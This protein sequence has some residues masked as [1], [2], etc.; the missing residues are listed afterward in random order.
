M[1]PSRPWLTPVSRVLAVAVV[2]GA[3][4]VGA[5][6]IGAA[7]EAT[8]APDGASSAAT[9]LTTSYCPG[10]P[11]AGG[12]EDSPAVDVTGAIDAMAA[13]GE[14]LDGV[15]SPSDDP[16]RITVEELSKASATDPKD[17]SESGP[18]Q[19]S[20]DELGA[21]SVRVRG[22]GERAPGL[23][24]TESFTASGEDVQGLAALP[25]AAPTADA[26]LV[27]GG[28]DRGRQERLVLT[29]PGGNAVSARVEAVGADGGG[30]AKDRSVVVPAGGRS[31]VLL[32]SLGGTEAPQ[33]VHVTTTGG[34][35][36]PVIVDQHLDGLTPAGV[37][38]VGPTAQPGTR[39]VLPGN[40][41]GSD[42]GLVIAAPGDRDA[43]VQ[44]RRLSEDA[45]RSAEVV[46][47]PA[48]EV[49]DVDLETSD[50][51]RSWVV[52]SD[53]PVVAASWTRVEGTQG[54]SD[55]AWSV[56]TPAIGRLAGVALPSAS[57]D[58]ARTF[59]E[60]TAADAPAEVEVLVSRD[61][62]VSTEE[63][64][65]DKARSKALPVGRADAVWVRP[66]SGRVHSAALVLS[67]P[68]AQEAQA[69]SLP[70]LPSRVAVRDVPVV[71]AR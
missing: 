48:G 67:A 39:L 54:R 29:N 56:A 52:E 2:A 64:S 34:L 68:G 11:F 42:R 21:E 30:D 4:V 51:M 45:A 61:G 10:D 36:A 62:E 18:T 32:D 7:P 35:V 28:G 27:A 65:L 25:C 14:V 40:A 66:V 49:F 47:V 12:A 41:N 58:D 44:V 33:A 57:A 5:D 71:Q 13:P 60:V 69:A 26:W 3:G 37:D 17:S 15:V 1:R 38:V 16:G 24:A 59:V 31:T 9:T 6:R 19:V 55:M 53:E 50:G 46:T 70:L 23:V 63:V 20:R 8:S 22:T 43:V